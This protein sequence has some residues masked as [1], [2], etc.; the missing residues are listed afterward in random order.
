MRR[1]VWIT[2]AALTLVGAGIAVAHGFS[3]KSVKAVSATITATTASN[4]S[5]STCT[6]PDGTY[7]MS[8][9]TFTGTS[10]SSDSTLNGPITVD[11]K[12]LINT[13]TGIGVVSGRIRIDTSGGGHTHAEFDTTYTGGNI[14]GL[15]EG[16]AQDA[17]L[18]GNISGAY[19]AASGFTNGKLGGGTTGGDAVEVLRGGCEPTH[20]PKPDRIEVHGAVSAVSGTL[21]TVAGVT[22]AVNQASLV[23]GIQIGDQVKMKC[24]S[25]NGTT[26]LEKVSKSGHH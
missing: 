19:S 4:V 11:A 22:C 15:A 24:T 16:H 10:T 6:G 2:M 17:K 25:S 3:S 21:I 26:T 8:R 13:T 7:A 18:I 1:L 5:T 12:S 9:G 14:A 23:S 20:A